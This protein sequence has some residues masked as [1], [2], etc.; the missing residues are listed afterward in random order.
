MDIR[1]WLI[2][3]DTNDKVHGH[4]HNTNKLYEE[5][6]LCDLFLDELKKETINILEYTYMIQF[7]KKKSIMI[8]SSNGG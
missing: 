3:N 1:Q 5:R 4:E 2:S 6:Q 8:N 7:I